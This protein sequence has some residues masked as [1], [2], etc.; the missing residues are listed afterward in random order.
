MVLAEISRGVSEGQTCFNSLQL[1]YSRLS[2]SSVF[3]C[4]CALRCTLR[5]K[6]EPLS[7]CRHHANCVQDN[8]FSEL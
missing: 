2:R 4:A 8:L 1:C 3:S 7:L 5:A 6:L